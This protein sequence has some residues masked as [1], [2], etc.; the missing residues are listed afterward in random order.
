[1]KNKKIFIPLL[2]ILLAV[3]IFGIITYPKKKE[4]EVIKIGAI[5]PLTG[6]AA[7]PGKHILNGLMISELSNNNKINLIIEDSKSSP[8]DGLFAFNKLYNID[9]IN[10][11][12]ISLS[13]VTLSILP[14]L[15][16]KKIPTFITLSNYPDIAMQSEWAFRFFINSTEEGKLVSEFLLKNNKKN[17]GILHMNDEGSLG[18][19]NSFK[20]SYIENGGKIR[21]VETFDVNQK[22]FKNIAVKV[23][24]WNVDAIVAIGYGPALGTLIFQLREARVNVPII[25]TTPLGAYD[26][27]KAARDA[28]FTE[29]YYIV[30]S[31]EV[32]K[33]DTL[34]KSFINLYQQKY[35]EIPDFLGAYGFDL[36]NLIAWVIEQSDDKFEAKKFINKVYQYSGKGV[37]GFIRVDPK[38]REILSNLVIVTNKDKNFR[39]VFP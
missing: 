19:V 18:S 13:A 2:L 9:K 16:E 32:N 36:G 28:M 5:L 6:P 25:S 39:K 35:G 26:A 24:N 29:V 1:M 4:P 12:I 33:E 30:P 37:T 11:L 21:F 8:K 20:K 14:H 27:Q 34:I 22:E 10:I 3:I 23:V 17:I 7:L 38:T 15:S 31:F